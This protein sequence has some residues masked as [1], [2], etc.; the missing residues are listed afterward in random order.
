MVMLTSNLAGRRKF[1]YLECGGSSFILN[2]VFFYQNKS[3]YPEDVGS[4]FHR[5]FWRSTILPHTVNVILCIF[6][7]VRS[8]DITKGRT[9]II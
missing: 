6:T 1:F 7:A 9:F 8:P 2:V 4:R 5:N 3:L